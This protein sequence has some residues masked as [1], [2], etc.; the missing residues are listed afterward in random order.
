MEATPK[1]DAGGGASR[2]P[3]RPF[4]YALRHLLV[5]LAVIWTIVL[6]WRLAPR[7]FASTQ[8]GQPLEVREFDEAIQQSLPIRLET[9]RSYFQ[10]GL[11]LSGAL[12]ALYIGK[13][14][15]TRVDLS[16]GPESILFLLM[17]VNFIVSFLAH[18]QYTEQIADWINV[19][20]ASGEGRL[21]IPDLDSAPVVVLI[22]AQKA[23]FKM[24]C[25]LALLT[26]ISGRY[27]R[28]PSHEIR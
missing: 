10:L 8:E 25:V 2:E 7:Y 17:N 15:E 18:Y 20:L 22:E 4:A 26:F 3:S 23:F 16:Q 5:Y 28:E 24:G 14:S 9:S 1:A 6:G 13:T 21:E 11:V 12:W 27:L 19:G